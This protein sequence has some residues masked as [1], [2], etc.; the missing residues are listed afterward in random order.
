MC[1]AFYIFARCVR[2]ASSPV[3]VRFSG[4]HGLGR[5]LERQR[6]VAMTGRRWIQDK[7]TNKVEPMMDER[8]QN[9]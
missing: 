6:G 1:G 8:Q 7:K 5:Q 2:L 4:E 9:S 3:I